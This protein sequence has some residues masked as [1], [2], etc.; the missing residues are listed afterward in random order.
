ME[1]N[2]TFKES[3]WGE[4]RSVHGD[5]EYGKLENSHLSIGCNSA[6]RVHH[7]KSA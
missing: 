6:R 5:Q 2:G 3:V 7:D 4:P 1:D